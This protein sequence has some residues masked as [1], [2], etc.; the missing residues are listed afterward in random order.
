MNEAKRPPLAKYKFSLTITG[1]SHEEIEREMLFT[2][3]G[4]YTLDSDY[5]KRDDFHVIGGRQ[6]AILEHINP[7][8]TAKR[9]ESELKEW[10][11]ERRAT[12]KAQSDE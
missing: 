7:D 9:Y 3:N 6:T 11:A 4:G 8:M 10:S 5:Y 12:R 2:L 1:N